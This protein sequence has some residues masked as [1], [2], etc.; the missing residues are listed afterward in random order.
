M[1][2]I[3]CAPDSRG[4]VARATSANACRGRG[5]D[6]TNHDPHVERPAAWPAAGEAG[7]RPEQRLRP[8]TSGPRNRVGCMHG[9]ALT[10]AC[11]NPASRRESAPQRPEPE[12]EPAAQR[13]VTCVG[14]DHFSDLP[15]QPQRGKALQMRAV[16]LYTHH[17]SCSSDRATKS[18]DRPSRRW[19]ATTRSRLD[20]L[21]PRVLLP[22]ERGRTAPARN[23]LV[24]ASVG[25]VLLAA[26][27]DDGRR[28]WRGLGQK[29][30]ADRRSCALERRRSGSAPDQLH[31]RAGRGPRR[32][33]TRTDENSPRRPGQPRCR[34]LRTEGSAVRTAH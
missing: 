14:Y 9:E 24:V 31:S 21:M 7:N 19:G 27:G 30:A 18:S 13:L 8:G 23:L 22:F 29:R 15:V 26:I 4:R 33:G 28:H 5:V 11:P 1:R 10:E 16:A 12:R 3:G 20:D 34:H 25:L 2:R 17:E 6:A 32:A